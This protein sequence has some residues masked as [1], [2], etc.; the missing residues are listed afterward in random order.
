LKKNERS[1]WNKQPTG[2][3]LKGNKTKDDGI[4]TQYVVVE[5]E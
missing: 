5:L 4:F 2:K 3:R 1:G